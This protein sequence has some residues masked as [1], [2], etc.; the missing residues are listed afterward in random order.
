MRNWSV[1]IPNQNSWLSAILLTLI[2]IPISYGQSL[3]SVLLS[4][5]QFLLAILSF[6]F[7]WIAPDLVGWIINI[8]LNIY[9]FLFY[10]A[11]LWFLSPIFLIAIAHYLLHLF[12]DRY[13]P[14]LEWQPAEIRMGLVSILLSLWEGLYG[15]LVIIFSSV[16]SDV[17][18]AIFPRLNS[19]FS[20]LQDV[21]AQEIS[22]WFFIAVQLYQPVYT[23]IA[24]LLIWVIVVAYLYQFECL[25]RQQLNSN[26]Q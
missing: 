21:T 17:F 10:L 18:M 24:R 20:L 13:F 6:I 16:V 14:D 19:D 9:N 1:W 3:I 5:L 2:F 15:W 23:P 12:L 4:W 22:R 26:S 8:I 7:A 25:V 11:P